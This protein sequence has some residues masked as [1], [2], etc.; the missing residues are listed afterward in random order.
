MSSLLASC[1]AT[2]GLYSWKTCS[3]LKRNEMD[4]EERGWDLCGE[5]SEGKLQLEGIASEKNKLKIKI[6]MHHCT[7]PSV[8]T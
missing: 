3:F 6:P 1:Q 7:V 5:W 4:L 2:F 8:V